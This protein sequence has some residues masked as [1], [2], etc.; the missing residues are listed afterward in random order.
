MNES[1]NK[2][3]GR[4]FTKVELHVNNLRYALP[5]LYTMYFTYFNF[6]MYCTVHVESIFKLYLHYCVLYV[7][8][9]PFLCNFIS[10]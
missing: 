1:Y 6:K 4:R 9:L 8:Q 10:Q 5:V 7:L 2:M 3:N